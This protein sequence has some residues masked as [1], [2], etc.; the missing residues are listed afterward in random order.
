MITDTVDQILYEFTFYV[1][2]GLTFFTV[3]PKFYVYCTN[4]IR[5]Y[6]AFK[7]NKNP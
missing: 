1:K 4:V 2:H 7:S 5:I 6:F 3:K